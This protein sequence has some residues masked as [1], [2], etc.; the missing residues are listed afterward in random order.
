MMAYNFKFK[1]VYFEN[2]YRDDDLMGGWSVLYV[3]FQVMYTFING[4]S[5][6]ADDCFLDIRSEVELRVEEMETSK[7]FEIR[8]A[9]AIIFFLAWCYD[10][11]Q[12]YSFSY[13][14]ERFWMVHDCLHA[15]KDVLG[16]YLTVGPTI[17]EERIMDTIEWYNENNL[18]IPDYRFRV[19]MD[20]IIKEFRERWNYSFN[21]GKACK[22]AGIE[23]SNLM[24]EYYE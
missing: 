12:E 10:T 14:G 6:H 15:K 4:D 22:L 13:E 21:F 16:D 17:E 24:L 9:D 19:F 7:D 5:Y 8:N 20:N 3:P 11:D 23:A 1:N 18:K 2:I